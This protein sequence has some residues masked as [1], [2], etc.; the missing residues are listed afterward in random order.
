MRTG[1]AFLAAL[2]LSLT[3]CARASFYLQDEWTG[4]EFY[5]GWN[6]E[7]END[8][9]H[10]RVNYV[11]QAE[12]LGKNLTYVDSSGAF[13][14]R[15][16]D[17]SIVDPAARGRD[18]IRISSQKAYDEAI[19]VLDL[20]HMPAG[21]STWPAFWTLSK[22]GPWPNGGEIDIIEGVNLNTHNQ[23]TLHT[24][25]N[26]TMPPDWWRE[27]QTGTTADSNCDTAANFNAGCGVIFTDPL[28]SCTSYG[29]PFNRAGGGYF[30]M[31]KGRDSVKVWFYPRDGYVP[32]VIRDGAGRGQPVR[33]DFTWGLPAANFPFFPNYCNY[34]EHFDAHQIVFDLT[35]CVGVLSTY[36]LFL[37]MADALNF[38]KGDWAGSDGVWPT[39]GCG[40]G[41]CP[42]FVNNNPSAFAEAYWEINSLR[43]YTSQW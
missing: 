37:T 2:S 8:P 18:S 15:A 30:V 12:A 13:V 14:M 41:T 24:T 23:A 40:T 6:W 17:W 32:R 31:Y 19:F 10:G 27:P 39:S 33:P 5:Q 22:A 38:T 36:L 3:P 43:V 28:P 1:Y 26:C 25:P 7:T 16:D 4:E 42:D 34:A 20:E 9:T 35:F 21:C 29:A 11:S